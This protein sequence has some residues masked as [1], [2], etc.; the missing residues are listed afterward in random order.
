M[1][2]DESRWYHHDL[3]NPHWIK[4]L[5]AA[6]TFL[7]IIVWKLRLLSRPIIRN[8]FSQPT[9]ERLPCQTPVLCGWCK[10]MFCG[11]ALATFICVSPFKVRCWSFMNGPQ[12]HV[13]RLLFQRLTSISLKINWSLG[14]SYEWFNKLDVDMI[15]VLRS[16]QSTL[17]R[18]V[19]VRPLIWILSYQDIISLNNG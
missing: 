2:I 15:Y 11:L 14:S 7:V 16:A 8:E 10:V 5:Y 9:N 1:P 17:K 6:G 3:S 18:M 4:Y 19:S 12:N 13:D